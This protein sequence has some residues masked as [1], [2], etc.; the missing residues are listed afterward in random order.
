MKYNK[1][2]KELT[3]PKERR[4]KGEKELTVPKKK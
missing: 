4:N 3:G 2:E 1:G